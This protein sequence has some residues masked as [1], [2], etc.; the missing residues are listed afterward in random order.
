MAMYFDSPD[1]SLQDELEALIFKSHAMGMNILGNEQ[2]VTVIQE[3]G[4]LLP[5]LRT[6]RQSENRVQLRRQH[7]HRTSRTG[8]QEYLETK[9]TFKSNAK[10]KKFNAY[11]QSEKIFQ[12]GVKQSRCAIGTG[13]LSVT[14]SKTEYHFFCLI[15]FSAAQV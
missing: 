12:R 14:A 9:P 13:C 1:D 11:K 10:R 4:I 7:I 15:I 6:C 5:F 8:S 3:K 2:T